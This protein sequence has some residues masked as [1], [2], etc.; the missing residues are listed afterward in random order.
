LKDNPQT[1]TALETGQMLDDVYN[2][3]SDV[4]TLQ[5]SPSKEFKNSTFV[6]LMMVLIAGGLL[7]W[8]KLNS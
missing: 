2:L 3:K 1:Q 7:I 4:Q 8:Q 6:Y 5:K